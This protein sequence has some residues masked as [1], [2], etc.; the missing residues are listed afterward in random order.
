MEVS[1]W[2]VSNPHFHMACADI[3]V[4]SST[5]GKYYYCM[6]LDLERT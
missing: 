2:V 5:I 1:M 4:Q 3:N 6:R